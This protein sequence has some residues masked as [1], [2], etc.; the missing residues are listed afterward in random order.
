MSANLK[1]PLPF[2]LA[3]LAILA[4]MLAPTQ[5]KAD[6]V[7]TSLSSFNAATSGNTT[8]TFNGIAAPGGFVTEASP[9]TF[10]GATFSTT[11]SL[12]VI[13]PGFYGFSYSNGG[14]LNADYQQPDVITVTLPSVTAVG[15][16]FGGLFGS[17]GPYLV[18]LSDGF[19]ATLSSSGS[20]A[21]NDL[22]F[23]G[24]TSS[25][26]LTS[27]TLTLPDTPSYNALDNFVY[28]SAVPEP[29]TL[30]LLATGLLGAAGAIRRR[31]QN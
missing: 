7:F 18:T 9:A 1:H 10:A 30:V 20:A 27:L 24:F 2:C 25:T 12:F 6:T 4:V 28:G 29:G 14:F 8:I 26:P 13:D 31:S 21:G 16:D 15:F 3:T 22:S 5:S 19:S 11:S 17:T 23:V